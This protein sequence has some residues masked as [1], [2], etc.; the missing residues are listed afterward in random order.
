MLTV[1]KTD[2]NILKGKYKKW[3]KVG[4]DPVMMKKLKEKTLWVSVKSIYWLVLRYL[5]Q[6]FVWMFCL[7]MRLGCWDLLLLLYLD[8]SVPLFTEVFVL[9][10]WWHWCSVHVY[11]ELLYLLA[12]FLYYCLVTFFISSDWILNKICLVWCETS[13]SCLLLISVYLVYPFPTFNF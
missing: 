1:F 5:C 2:R 11:L 7:L 10:T 8:L 9:W 13:F 4:R 6:F 3:S 12:C